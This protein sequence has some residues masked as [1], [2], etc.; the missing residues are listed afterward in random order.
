MLFIQGFQCS[1][2]FFGNR[3]GGTVRGGHFQGSGH[4][5]AGIGS[6]KKGEGESAEEGEG[7]GGPPAAPRTHQIYADMPAYMHTL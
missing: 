3:E 7:R 6:K 2:P 4:L 1:G 5:G